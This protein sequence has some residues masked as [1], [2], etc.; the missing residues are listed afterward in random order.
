MISG[1]KTE[2]F[3]RS[4]I[5]SQ[6]DLKEATLNRRQFAEKQGEQLQNGGTPPGN[7]KRVVTLSVANP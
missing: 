3:D 4:D 5:V 1:Y 7:E 2:R 6:D